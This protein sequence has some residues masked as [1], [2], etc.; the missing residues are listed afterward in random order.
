MSK[1]GRDQGL[2]LRSMDTVHAIVRCDREGAEDPGDPRPETVTESVTDTGSV[3]RQGDPGSDT[4]TGSDTDSDFVTETN[5][6][7][8]AGSRSS[9]SAHIAELRHERQ[10]PRDPGIRRHADVGAPHARGVRALQ[11]S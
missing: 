1:F 7:A 2:A 3:G 9:G 8:H 11:R 5:P 6:V 10:A 4:D